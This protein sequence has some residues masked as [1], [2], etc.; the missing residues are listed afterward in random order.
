MRAGVDV[1]VVERASYAGGHMRT[2][3]R[4]NWRYEQGPNS[5]LGSATAI[6]DLA[7]ELGLQPVPA[8]PDASRRYLVVDGKLTELP[9]SPPKLLSSP[10]LGAGGKLRLLAE[11][12]LPSKVGDDATVRDFFEER[13]GKQA[14]ERLVDAFVGGIYAGDIDQLGM[15]AAFPR[16]WELVEEH[17]SLFRGMLASRKKKASA[18]PADSLANI[19]SPSKGS[20]SSRDTPNSSDSSSSVVSQSSVDSQSSMDSQ[21]SGDFRSSMDSSGASDSESPVDSPS[22]TAPSP[23]TNQASSADSS[24]RSKAGSGRGTW[25]FPGGLGDLPTALAQ[26]LGHRLELEKEV[27]LQRDREGWQVDGEKVDAL[28]I[29]TPA[30]AAAKLLG[31]KAPQLAQLL[32]QLIYAPV[33]VLHLLFPRERVGKTLDGFGFLVPRS[34]KL[35]FLGCIWNSALFEV[36][37]PD[38]LAFTVMCGGRDRA[39]YELGDEEL[40]SLVLSDLGPLLELRGPPLDSVVI[41]HDQAIPQPGTAHLRWKAAV[42]HELSEVPGLFLCGNYLAG[43][44]VGETIAQASKSAKSALAFLAEHA[45]SNPQPRPHSPKPEQSKQSADAGDESQHSTSPLAPLGK[46]KEDVS[47]HASCMPEGGKS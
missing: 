22:S 36:C 43:V 21:S 17:G 13:L 3:V 29:A 38:H 45:P 1:A 41:R 42:E 9:S 47:A 18:K 23:Q 19:P 6:F 25:S 35:S 2:L 37:S 44:S 24:A 10:V 11:P 46:N 27:R 30:P 12:L 26:A 20:P 15:A 16:L 39:I 14:T 32:D 7:K 28:L 40:L 34:E 5:F 4:E 31:P 8:S 33:A